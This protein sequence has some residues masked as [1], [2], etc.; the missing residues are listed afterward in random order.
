[1]SAILMDTNALVWFAN[2]DSILPAALN[3]IARAQDI[4]RIY[5]SSI[6][7][8]EV[9]LAA[10]KWTNR[11][12]L[13]GLNA[14]QWFSAVLNI[15]GIKLAMPSRRIALEAA[16][17]PPIYGSGDPGDC[18]LI[19][20]ARVKRVP[21]VTRDAAMIGLSEVDPKYLKTIPC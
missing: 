11:P 1:M 14:Q 17:V 6:S 21:I 15:S 19:A 4:G 13:G 18:F 5:V 2:G 8:W 16:E 3:A 12:N 20:T 9:S 7:A 10:K